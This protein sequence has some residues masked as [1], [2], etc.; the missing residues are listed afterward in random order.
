MPRKS[1]EV[2]RLERLL[3]T[4][5]RREA[6]TVRALWDEIHTTQES[7]N[8]ANRQLQILATAEIDRALEAGESWA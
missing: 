3:T 1:Q 2:Q 7:L 5:L 8:A 6:D 4:Q